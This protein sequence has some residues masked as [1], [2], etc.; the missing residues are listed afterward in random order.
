LGPTAGEFVTTAAATAAA[1]GFMKE[2]QQRRSLLSIC[3]G[4]AEVTS[5]ELHWRPELVACPASLQSLGL[6]Y[7]HRLY[8]AMMTRLIEQSP[9]S[10]CIG[11]FLGLGPVLF[12]GRIYS[13]ISD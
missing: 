1:E 4:A 10:G 2:C 11:G 13:S 12:L 8:L 3:A 6:T 7:M 9:A 5:N